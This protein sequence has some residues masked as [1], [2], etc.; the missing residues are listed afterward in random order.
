MEYI[1]IYQ[2]IRFGYDLLIQLFI[3][4]HNMNKEYKYSLG[5]KLKNEA[6]N[7]IINIYKA[8]TVYKKDDNINNARENLEVIRLLI[9][10]L[11]D[12]NQISINKYISLNMDIEDISKQLL[13]WYRMEKK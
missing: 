10:I 4:V 8:N 13:G 1:L 6:M 7:L 12:M 11:R 5:E 9:R 2:Y 3:M